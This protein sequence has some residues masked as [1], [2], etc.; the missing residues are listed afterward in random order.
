MTYTTILVLLINS[1]FDF[2]ISLHYFVD[3]II[4]LHYFVEL[5]KVFY[6]QVIIIPTDSRKE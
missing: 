6:P 1:Y 5:L 4:L 2:I 3:F